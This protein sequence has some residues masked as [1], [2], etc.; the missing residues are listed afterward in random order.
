MKTIGLVGGTTP[1]ST[2]I[3]YEGLIDGA[4]RPGGNPLHNPEIIIYSLN[5]A[6]LVRLQ[7]DGERSEV[8]DFLLDVLQRLQRAGAEIGSFTANTPHTYL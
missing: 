2:K 5:L 4:R 8:V 1:E 3:Y 7:R 6:E